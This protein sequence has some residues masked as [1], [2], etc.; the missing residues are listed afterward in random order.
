MT[1]PKLLKGIIKIVKETETKVGGV[2][3][4]SKLEK[5]IA[6]DVILSMRNM[7]YNSIRNLIEKYEKAQESEES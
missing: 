3:E 6:N 1:K 2:V 4:Q 5:A 7:G